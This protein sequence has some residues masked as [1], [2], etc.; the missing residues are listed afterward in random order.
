VIYVETWEIVACEAGHR[1]MRTRPA[2][3][4]AIASGSPGIRCARCD[5]PFTVLV[6]TRDVEIERHPGRPVI[7]TVR[8]AA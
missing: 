3:V 6:A 8:G 4:G 1:E 5:R 7:E 2:G